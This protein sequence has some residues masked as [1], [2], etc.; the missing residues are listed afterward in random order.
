MR[1]FPILL[2]L[3]LGFIVLFP[4]TMDAS[5]QDETEHKP[6]AEMPRIYSAPPEDLTPRA[7][8]LRQRLQFENVE[9][10]KLN[11]SL[12]KTTDPGTRREI[13]QAI[14]ALKKETEIDLTRIQLKHAKLA[15]QA[16]MVLEL[17]NALKEMTEQPTLKPAGDRDPAVR[18][19]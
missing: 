16:E 10:A 15:G 6:T 18:T 14:N 3:F 19:H 4:G 5:A 12:N 7:F 13:L 1:F 8:E 9:L 2:T 11:T 17:E